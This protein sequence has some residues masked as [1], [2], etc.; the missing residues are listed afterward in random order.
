MIAYL[1]RINVGFAAL[2][3]R[4]QLHFSDRVYGLGAGIFF[5]GYFVFQLPSNL[6]LQRI[7][8]RR[9]ISILMLT[10]GLISSS[11]M[12]VLTAREFYI[13]R[14]LLGAAEAGFFPGLVLYVKNW[15][16]N[17]IRA[18]TVARFM[19]A[20][21][22]AG[23]FGGPVS[24]MLLNLNGHRGLAGWQWLFLLE[25]I[26]ALLMGIVVLNYLTDKPDDAHWLTTIQR[27]WLAN[28]LD[29]E[30]VHSLRTSSS[31]PLA[32]LTSG[33][34]WLLAIV[35][36]GASTCSY[37]MVLWLPTLIHS[38][39][40]VGNLMIGVLT[41]IPLLG[42]AT[43]MTLVS[44]HSDRTG[45]RSWHVTLAALTG[46]AALVVLAYSTSIVMI[47]IAATF[48]AVST[49]SLFGPF[50]A[51]ATALLESSMAAAG[52]AL[53]NSIGNL[54]GFFGPYIIGFVRNAT[55]TFRGGFLVAAATLALCG[56]MVPLISLKSKSL[57]ATM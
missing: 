32:S 22:L 40:S 57:G 31:K 10:W 12:F 14:F 5:T 15:F 54:G 52:I 53:I 17:E 51:M 56:L 39:S 21:P 25:G 18:R 30:R 49:Y 50:W 29:H 1:D 8:A 26:P 19:A 9:W 4:E 37:A 34:V 45:E 44:L 24:G 28:T 42:A 35:V 7:G 16:P 33:L 13:L 55:G 20:G 48:A 41:A 36:F 23:V 11:T 47:V 2:Q 43:G 6:I 46:A 27:Q 38:R 3:M